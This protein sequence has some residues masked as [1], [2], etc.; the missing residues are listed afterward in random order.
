MVTRC[1]LEAA[2]ERDQRANKSSRHMR[3]QLLPLSHFI[4]DLK[5]QRDGR[6]AVAPSLVV[7]LSS[8]RS[9]M[10]AID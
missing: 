8:Q 4:I 6:N 2:A 5:T 1:Q 3:F 9:N 7:T 10:A